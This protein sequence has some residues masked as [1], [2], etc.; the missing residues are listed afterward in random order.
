MEIF[1]VI[2]RIVLSNLFFTEKGARP[3]F[4]SLFMSLRGFMRFLRF[5]RKRLGNPEEKTEKR[6]QAPFYVTFYVIAR[7]KATW[8]SHKE[9]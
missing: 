6:G 5:A 7:S 3:L 4:M 9:K 8:Q 2:D 1:Y